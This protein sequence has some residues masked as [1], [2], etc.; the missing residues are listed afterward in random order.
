[1]ALG[2][3]IEQLKAKK[4]CNRCIGEAYLS[5]QVRSTGIRL[6]CSYC[7]KTG[8]CY[9]L[10]KISG[11]VDAAFQQHYSR[12]SDQPNAWES[13]MLAD[14]ESDFEWDRHGDPVEDAIMNAA[15]IPEQAAADIQRVLEEEYA[16]YEARQMGD[17]TEYASGSHYEVKGPSDASWEEEWQSLEYTLKTETRFFSRSAA[18]HLNSVFDGIGAMKTHTG[19]SLIVVA[20]PK[21]A[22]KALYR[23]RVFQSDEKLQEALARPDLH[24]GS[25]PSAVA[26]N[27]RMNAHG[28]S[29]F[30]GAERPQVAL[31]EVRPP[32]G[33]QVAV[34]RFEIIRPLRLLDLAALGAV[35]TL[36]SIFDPNFANQLEREEFLRSLSRRMTKPVMP[37]D[38]AFEYLP[39]Q[40]VADFL[41]SESTIPLDGII[42]P[43]VQ[44]GAGRNIALFHKAA[45]VEE[46]EIPARTRIRV[47]LGMMTQDGW[48][49]DYSVLEEVTPKKV[50]AKSGKR[51]FPRASELAA[52]LLDFSSL[53]P[54][55]RLATLRVALDSIKVHRVK[56]VRFTTTAYDVRRYRWEKAPPEF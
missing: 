38:E 19:R 23:A 45:R 5:E 46:I 40:A 48:E 54:D 27:N 29:V 55:L 11:F 43:S 52:L 25:P 39:T 1:M 7:G 15:D 6:T 9:R 50:S 44:A 36:G 24:L 31:A 26:A 16:D 28:I 20:G 22:I 10:D 21:S 53:N 17:E 33:S 35:R 8:Q 34:A 4:L 32:V 37:D 12:T 49:T 51:G 47:H 13:A 14:D 42:F 30:Y 56:A 3:Q 2:D 18:S 41:A